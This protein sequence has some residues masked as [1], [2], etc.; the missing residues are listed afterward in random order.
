MIIEYNPIS[1]TAG[2]GAA[3]S[4]II[5]KTET[6]SNIAIKDLSQI[7]DIAFLVQHPI[8]GKEMEWKDLVSDPLT[9]ADCTLSAT[10]E[11]GRMAQGVGKNAD[12]TQRTKGTNTIFF[13]PANKVP[14]GRKVTYI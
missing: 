11:L 8:T 13:I 9:S 3:L 4:A 10:N 1:F 2:Y 6:L 14:F 12:S 7:Q 5:N